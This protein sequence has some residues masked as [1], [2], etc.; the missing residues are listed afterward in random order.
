MKLAEVR[1][2][3]SGDGHSALQVPAGLDELP[4]FAV[5]HG[6]IGDALKQMRAFFDG[7]QEIAGVPDFRRAA[8]HGVEQAVQLLPHFRADLLAN[9][10]RIFARVTMLA[11][12]E[13]RLDASCNS[14]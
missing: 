12:I 14:D 2:H 6:G 11:T 5:G 1:A 10:P 7:L 4:A 3:Q 9:L 13:E 8:A